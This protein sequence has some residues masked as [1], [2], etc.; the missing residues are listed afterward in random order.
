MN[1]WNFHLFPNT[2][3][4]FVTFEKTMMM[5]IKTQQLIG[6]GPFRWQFLC[7]LSCTGTLS[8]PAAQ[9]WSS[10]LQGFLSVWMVDHTPLRLLFSS[11]NNVLQ[12]TCFSCHPCCSILCQGTNLGDVGRLLDLNFYGQLLSQKWVIFWYPV[13]VRKVAFNTH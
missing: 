12:L 3:T 5:I 8:I 7:F 6:C 10:S 1:I 9:A 11:F 13:A 2:I 4:G